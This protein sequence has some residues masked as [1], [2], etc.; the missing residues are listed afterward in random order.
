MPEWATNTPWWI[1]FALV[2]T[3]ATVLIKFSRWTGNVDTRLNTLDGSVAEVQKTLKRILERLSPPPAVQANSPIQ[4][5]DFGSE[6]SATGNASE[7]A[8]LHAQGLYALADGKEEFEVFDLCVSYV[9]ELFATDVDF[10]HTIRSTAYQHGTEPEHVLKVF[11]V[12][13]RDRLL[14]GPP[15]ALG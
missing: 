11:Q 3:L 9:D 7:W 10:K 8:R 12:E 2:L 6:I 15:S 13:L 5:T 4:L 1:V 14:Q